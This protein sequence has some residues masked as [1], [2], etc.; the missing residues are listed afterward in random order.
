[1]DIQNTGM[2]HTVYFWLKD[3][4]NDEDRQDFVRAAKELAIVP[5]VR[6]FYGGPPAGT[7][8]RDVT[9]HDFDYSI[10]LIFMSVKDHNTYQQDPVH[11]K[12]VETQAHKFA[13]VKVFDSEF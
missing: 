13:T 8:D 11:L 9:N 2:I 12:F 1:M 6:K 3:D 7:P 4:L 10:H 5:T